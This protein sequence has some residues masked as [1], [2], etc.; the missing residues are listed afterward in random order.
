MNLGIEDHGRCENVAH[1]RPMKFLSMQGVKLTYLRSPLKYNMGDLYG[2]LYM[3]TCGD[4]IGELHQS[5]NRA[6]W[7]IQHP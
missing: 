2:D 3:V 4:H 7:K 1:Q 5:F 6:I